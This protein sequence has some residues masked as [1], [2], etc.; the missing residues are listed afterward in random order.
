MPFL[1]PGVP[2]HLRA[3]KPEVVALSG[4]DLPSRL[5][6]R[7]KELG[8]HQPE[9]AALLGIS[10]A[11]MWQWEMGIAVPEDRYYPAII[12][13]LGYEPWPEPRTDGERFRAERLR[14]G[15]SINQAARLVHLAFD[16]VA[17]FEKDKRR[18]SPANRTKLDAFMTGAG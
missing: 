9:A 12:C 1:I 4:D 18:L 14:R 11:S 13:F 15:L 3:I 8:L 16:T 6:R 2:L 7:R 17:L 5:R 10:K